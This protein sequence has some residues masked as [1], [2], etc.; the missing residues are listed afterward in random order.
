MEQRRPRIAGLIGMVALMIA[1]TF[2]CEHLVTDRG[3]DPAPFRGMRWLL[4]F[5]GVAAV[6]IVLGGA[7]RAG[8]V[9]GGL[10]GSV[11][12]FV[13]TYDDV[14]AKMVEAF[15]AE[16]GGIGVVWVVSLAEL[17]LLVPALV[18]FGE[19]LF[20]LAPNG[21]LGLLRLMLTR[22]PEPLERHRR[23][24]LAS[25]LWLALVFGGWIAYA[26]YLGI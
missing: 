18:V 17:V 2:A 25:G 1:A 10:L 15:G 24:L 6:L 20:V 5:T 12:L 23:R 11:V 7:L 21:Q 19:A 14:Q 22:Q 26:E 13:N 4:G 8:W 16:V 9:V 3:G